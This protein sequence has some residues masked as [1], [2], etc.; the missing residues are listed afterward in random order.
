MQNDCCFVE[1]ER[2]EESLDVFHK[3]VCNGWLPE[4]KPLKHVFIGLLKF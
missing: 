4:T 3:L 1:K 2:K